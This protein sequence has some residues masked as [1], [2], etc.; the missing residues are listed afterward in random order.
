MRF[1]RSVSLRI[2]APKRWRLSTEGVMLSACWVALGIYT[3]V[4]LFFVPGAD[5]KGI[6]FNS[7]ILAAS[8]TVWTFFYFAWEG[9]LWL[10]W[11]K[12]KEV[13]PPSEVAEWQNEEDLCRPP[14]WISPEAMTDED[15]AEDKSWLVQSS[16]EYKLQAETHRS[17]VR[18]IKG[19]IKD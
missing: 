2:P 16:E 18:R 8:L 3:V 14:T 7:L 17:R 15:I 13:L 5:G 1:G 11:F 10:K 19:P 4:F 9:W 6:I 12:K